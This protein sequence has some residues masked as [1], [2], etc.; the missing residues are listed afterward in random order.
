MKKPSTKLKKPAASEF[1]VYDDKT[2]VKKDVAEV[3]VAVVEERVLP[4]YDMDH[5]VVVYEDNDVF[6]TMG[7][8]MGKQDGD[9]FIINEM[10]RT[11]YEKDQPIRYKCYYVEFDGGKRT[12]MWFRFEEKKK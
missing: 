9:F 1:G 6:R 7:Q 11:K 10:F 8:A 5:A 12:R 3:P 2:A 4:G